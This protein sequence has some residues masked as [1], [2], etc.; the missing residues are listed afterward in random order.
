MKKILVIILS[1][2]MMLFNSPL[3]SKRLNESEIQ[4]D[5]TKQL[6]EDQDEE[7]NYDW[8]NQLYYEYVGDLNDHGIEYTDTVEAG[9][10][11]FEEFASEFEVNSTEYLSIQN[12]ISLAQNSLVVPQRRQSIAGL[13]FSAVAF[14]ASILHKLKQMLPLTFEVFLNSTVRHDSNYKFSPKHKNEV[15][16]DSQVRSFA[17]GQEQQAV[18]DLGSLE[19]N[20]SNSL[21]MF[22]LFTSLHGVTLAKDVNDPLL[23]TVS[24]TFDFKTRDELDAETDQTSLEHKANSFGCLLMH[25]L[26]V[27]YQYNI[28]F[29]VEYKDFIEPIIFQDHINYYD[30]TIM[31]HSSNN[32]NV[33]ACMNCTTKENIQ[34]WL[35]IND[36][37]RITI[38]AGGTVDLQ[39][40]KN[41]SGKAF[42]FSFIRGNRRIISLIDSLRENANY[43]IDLIYIPSYKYDD[44]ELIGKF[45]NNWVLE[46][47]NLNNQTRTLEYNAALVSDIEANSFLGLTQIT[48]V[49][50]APFEKATISIAINS[51]STIIFRFR[52][53]LTERKTKITNMKTD[54][55]CQVEC[56][57][58]DFNEYLMLEVVS[59]SGN[60][61]NINI[62]N[63]TGLNQIV[64]YNSKMCFANDAKNWTNLSNIVSLYFA[65]GE[66]KEVQIQENLF[67]NAIVCSYMCNNKRVITYGRNLKSSGSLDLYTNII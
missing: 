30:V 46:V 38:P 15:L 28:E 66:T 61:W 6:V 23:I 54:G 32:L 14:L 20:E 48:S 58:R 37:V 47:T 49:S 44:V 22:D 9:I 45:L 19:R 8:C 67:A 52:T 13:A 39:I 62:T 17:E 41:T 5:K 33:I 63:K 59:K 1:M 24:D 11:I 4:G 10:E 51:K 12:N 25:E 21:Y 18:R 60:K 26:K 36:A 43:N 55:S 31:N 50:I 57:T 27:I 53:L 40:E 29:T 42:G 35:N 56:V 7:P 65:S 16:S 3:K 64:Y 2:L 34:N